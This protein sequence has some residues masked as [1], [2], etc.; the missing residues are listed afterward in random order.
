MPIKF[1]PGPEIRL[2]PCFPGR[3]ISIKAAKEA[4]ETLP[5]LV[6]FL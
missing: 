4:L 6:H 2:V 3:L 5:V 1:P